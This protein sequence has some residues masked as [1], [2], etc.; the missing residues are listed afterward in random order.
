MGA[1]NHQLEI[2]PYRPPTDPSL[3]ATWST[4]RI[5]GLTVM[6]MIG[7][8][9]VQIVFYALGGGLFLPVLLGTLGGVFAPLYLLSRNLGLPVARDFSLR[10]ASP[11]VLVAAG[12]MALAALA[13]TSLLAQLSLRLH[14]AD[15]TW[16]ALMAE[17]MPTGG[18]DL[19]LAI[20]TVV[21]AAPL[22]EEVIFRG[23]L[24]RAISRHWGPWA[25]A[26]VS[27]LVFGIVHGQPWYL[28]GLIG[29][30]FVLAVVYEATGSV[31][32]CW[33]THMVHNGIS[34]GMMLWNNEATDEVAPLT[35]T[36]W[37]ITAGSLVFLVLLGRYLLQMRHPGRTRKNPDQT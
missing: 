26:I 1:M 24:H 30:G 19:G 9:A 10:G 5:L 23:L 14:P 17:N 33:V 37:L 22:A 28:F 20:L 11:V 4:G 2:P 15:P 16:V 7:D 13:P 27:S 25:A 34:L 3:W 32:A 18:L 29:I 31:W 36:D 21:V 8:F 6:L 12:L 35:V